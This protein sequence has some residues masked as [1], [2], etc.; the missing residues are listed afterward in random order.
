MEL[1]LSASSVWVLPVCCCVYFKELYNQ[2]VYEYEQLSIGI[3]AK[4]HE[5]VEPFAG[6]DLDM[7]LKTE[8]KSKVV[9]VLKTRENVSVDRKSPR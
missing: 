5:I 8:G 6:K 7:N 1:L 3:P 2:E 9:I 4:F